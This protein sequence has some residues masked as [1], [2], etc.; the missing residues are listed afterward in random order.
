[1]GKMRYDFEQNSSAPHIHQRRTSNG[2]AL[3]RLMH[4]LTN[5]SL[6]LI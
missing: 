1:M 5:L 2:A 6:N 3:M 4:Y